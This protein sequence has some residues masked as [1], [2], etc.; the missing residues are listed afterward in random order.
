MAKPT[1][2]AL[3]RVTMKE[4]SYLFVFVGDKETR[5]RIEKDLSAVFKKHEG[6]TKDGYIKVLDSVPE[7]EGTCYV[8]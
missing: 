4:F 2:A 3:A 1:T 5:D 8:G 7:A 6:D